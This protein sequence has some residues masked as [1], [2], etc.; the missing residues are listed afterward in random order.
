MWHWFDM[1][2]QKIKIVGKKT[3][4]IWSCHFIVAVFAVADVADFV[5]P[6]ACPAHVSLA[7][8]IPAR[9]PRN[10][11]CFPL[12]DC[13]CCHGPVSL[14]P[15]ATVAPLQFNVS[16]RRSEW[17][18][19]QPDCSAVSDGASW[20]AAPLDTTTV[21]ESE[22]SGWPVVSPNRPTVSGKGASWPVVSTVQYAVSR[23]DQV[24]LW[25]Q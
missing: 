11:A 5:L 19:A 8:G 14:V 24:G 13:D 15:M 4:C 23:R 10:N 18:A 17:P 2:C 16:G 12:I 20:Q 7:H 22:G 1:L 6:P 3:I 21:S 25:P 9:Q